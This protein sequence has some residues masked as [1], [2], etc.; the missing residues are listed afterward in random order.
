MTNLSSLRFGEVFEARRKELNLT[1][2]QIEKKTNI[3]LEYLEAIEN[4]DFEK[5]PRTVYLERILKKYCEFLDIPYS[6]IE[7]L[8]AR[9]QA[10]KRKQ[11]NMPGARILSKDES[12]FKY[13]FLSPKK[14]ISFLF[15]PKLLFS[16][17]SILVMSGLI[18]YFALLYASISSAPKLE[19]LEP[20]DNITVRSNNIIAEGFTDPG[21]V[22]TINGKNIS[23]NPQGYFKENIGLTSGINKFYIQTVGANGKVT[24][25][26]R[27][28][29]AEI[30]EPETITTD[31]K[32]YDKLEVKIV[33]QKSV[34]MR[35]ETDEQKTVEM[36]LNPPNE[37]IFK[38]EKTIT[39]KFGNAGGVKVFVNGKEQPPLGEIGEVLEK[40]YSLHELN[41]GIQ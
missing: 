14:N 12:V 37:K 5:L 13:L 32:L 16:I 28:I 27:T 40:T 6:I 7:K 17:I 1:T 15:T 9:E 36:I 23:V 3:R 4:S 22:T 19:L 8:W 26:E 33:A 30:D 38:A 41:N 39:F 21:N 35:V 31:T 2:Q 10:N 25:L 18:L 11:K 34:W 24:I 20:N 29:N